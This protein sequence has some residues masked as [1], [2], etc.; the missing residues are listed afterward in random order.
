MNGIH[1]RSCHVQSTSMSTS[2]DIHPNSIEDVELK[3]VKNKIA[4]IYSTDSFIH[5]FFDDVID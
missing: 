4:N 1:V 5:S 2:F 3:T